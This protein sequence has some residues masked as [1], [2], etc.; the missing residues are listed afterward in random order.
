MHSRE[1]SPSW[2]VRLLKKFPT[3]YTNRRSI[4]ASITAHPISYRSILVSYH[5]HLALPGSL[6]PSG[7]PTKALY[8]PLFSSPHAPF[9][10]TISFYFNCSPEYLVG[11]TSHKAALQ[12][13]WCYIHKMWQWL[14][15]FPYATLWGKRKIYF[16]NMLYAP[17]GEATKL[18]ML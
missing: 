18:N 6:I 5:L 15:V 4:N 3:S 16:R 13:M 1:E 14:F 11:N 12:D 17:V 10:T 9:A 2:S 8:A 7:F